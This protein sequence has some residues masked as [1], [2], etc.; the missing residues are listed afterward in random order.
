M[1]RQ[2]LLC[3]RRK[4]SLKAENFGRTSPARGG[5]QNLQEKPSARWPTSTFGA[6]CPTQPQTRHE[7]RQRH[8]RRDG[9]Q[10]CGFTF[11]SGE[12]GDDGVDEWRGR[13]GR[14]TWTTW[15]NIR[16][17][18][19][20]FLPLSPS[21]P[22]SSS[23]FFSFFLLFLPSS[24]FFFS[25]FL[26]LFL[27][28]SSSFFF[29]FLPPSSSSFLFLLPSSSF[30]QGRGGLAGAAALGRRRVGG[31]RPGAL[32]RGAEQPGRPPEAVAGGR[33]RW[34]EAAPERAWP[35]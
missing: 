5:F 7:G 11:S 30:L 17:L 12:G 34:G 18:H 28:S 26:L 15:M 27:P 3:K 8:K 6:R 16:P 33:P 2:V 22:P 24:S 29:L 10:P 19:L 32:L 31:V 9:R 21:P 14:M 23:F 25:F 35:G 1:A 13:H 4:T 20:G